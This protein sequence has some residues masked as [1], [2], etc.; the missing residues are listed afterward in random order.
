MNVAG[1]VC[2]DLKFVL[3]FLRLLADSST[4]CG[5]EDCGAGYSNTGDTVYCGQKDKNTELR[6]RLCCPINNA[7]DPKTCS[8][9]IGENTFET[10]FILLC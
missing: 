8:W 4:E 5:V 9:S 3:K 10:A 1:R 2:Q 6:K 7:P